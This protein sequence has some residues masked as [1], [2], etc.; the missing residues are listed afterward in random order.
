MMDRSYLHYIEQQTP[1]RQTLADYGVRYYVA[2]AYLPFTGCFHA[3][4][5]AKG[6]PASA[7]MRAEFCEAPAATYTHDGIG[8]AHLRSQG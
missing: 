4:E 6:G 1:L 5:P 7:K 2:T 8:D 3:A